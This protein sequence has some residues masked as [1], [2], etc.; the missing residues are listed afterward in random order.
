MGRIFVIVGGFLVLLLTAALVVPPFINWS[1]Y[2]ADF[3]R[4]ASR[5]LGRPV[6]VAG[7]ASARLLPFPSV[8]FSDVRVGASAQNPAM[9]VE[10]FSMGAELMP[11]LRGQLLI[12]DMRVERPRATI[13][14]DKDG[15]VDWAIRPSTPLNPGQ[16]K[17]EKLTISD[18]EINLRDDSSGRSHTITNLDAVLSA[19]SL[20]GPWLTNGRLNFD[21]EQVALDVNTG[22]ARPDGSL[23]MRVRVTP[24]AIPATF[25]TDGD[26]VLDDGQLRYAGNFALRSADIAT[27]KADGGKKPVTE[28]PFLADLRISGVFAADRSRFESAEFRM[29]Q[30]AGDNPYIVNGKALFDYGIEP[31][32]EINADGQQVFWGPTA[33]DENDQNAAIVPLAERMAAF[34]RMMEQLPIPTIPGSVDL[35][36]PAIIAGGTTIRTVNIQAE[37]DAGSWN[38]KQLE[39]DFPGRTKVEAKGRLSVGDNFGFEGDLLVASRQPSGLAA[40]LNENVDESIRRLPAAGFSGR[41]SLNADRQ[42][43]DNLEVGLGSTVLKGRF[44]R[45]SP[46]LAQASID[47]TLAGEAVESDALH[48][49]VAL[50]STDSSLANIGDQ[51]ISVDFKA[52]P[53]RFDDAEFGSVDTAFRLNHGRFD[54]DRLMIGDVGGATLTATGTLNPFSEEPSGSL[55]ATVLADDLSG[56]FTVLA[57]RFPQLPL[58]TALETRAQNY[59][60]LFDDS[61]IN[62]VANALTASKDVATVGPSE[63]SF[64]LSG[65]SGGMKLDLS[66]TAAG[67]VRGEDPMQIQMRA[68]VASQHGETVLALLGLPALPLGMAGPLEADLSLQGAP[69]V[70]MR[71]QLNLK[72]PDGVANVDGVITVLPDDLTASGKASMKAAD[73]QPF[74]A[75]LGY[76]LPG[77]GQGLPV[78]LS[79]DFQLAKGIL[80]FPGLIG[81]VDG[82]EVSAK[83]DASLADDGMPLLRGEAKLAVLDLAAL[84]D[85]MLGQEAFVGGASKGKVPSVWP[86]GTFSSAP[87]L[88]LLADM[89]I[90]AKQAD[91]GSFSP[92]K[93]FTAKIVKGV[94]DLTISEMNG[95]WSGGQLTGRVGLRNNDKN[96]MVSVDMV[97]NG[98]DLRSAYVLED[99]AAPLG[100]ILK[101]TTKLSGNGGNMAELVRSLAGSATINVDG[102]TLSGLEPEALQAMREQADRIGDLPTEASGNKSPDNKATAKQFEAIAS[103][104]TG[105]GSFAAGPA[106]LD[107]TVAGG[108][109]RMSAIKLANRN[110]E[111]ESELQIDLSTLNVTANGS[112][113][114]LA[115]T[116]A[117]VEAGTGSGSEPM[118]RFNV[119]GFYANPVVKV[120]HQPL[121]Q[122]LTQRALER[123]QERVEAMQAQLTEKQALRREVELYQAREAARQAALQQEEERRRTD[124]KARAAVKAKADAKAKADEEAQRAA[125]QRAAEQRSIG[126]EAAQPLN[127]P[128]I[129]L[130]QD[131]QSLNEFLKT[132]ESDPQP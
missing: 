80:R 11:F 43:I 91:L 29:E 82:N 32:F 19:T 86:R 38:I 83:I 57:A 47:L 13:S 126:G 17:V 108:V 127:L 20:S 118:L 67:A 93:D 104:A 3:E 23:R 73:I 61:E 28:K 68:N 81:Q 24:D 84:A 55:D 40:W 34:G 54:F 7:S 110:A 107:L 14:L 109:A 45:Q 115:G 95:T 103:S 125:E 30:G 130:P 76:T 25:E 96:A 78:D 120:D 52:G 71:T 51:A 112:F 65:K 27:R 56:F 131:G 70:G 1:G 48:G 88:P 59:P 22:E 41:V 75:T 132:L 100:G 36:L 69:S 39:A 44:A 35:R 117:G 60:G 74:A 111:L 2:R 97:W 21:G 102:L 9:T 77:F 66:G 49:L 18:G 119:H 92:I 58:F 128:N 122:F 123:E 79:S 116:D 46:R 99:G 114:L 4:E 53:V 10:R 26:M 62:L 105:R 16:I 50:F 12:F 37:P 124:A 42:T 89:K 31:H 90:T 72:A 106:Q 6:E 87:S 33:S 113:R 15:R 5:I 63:I 64:S 8:T 121:V 101:L 129:A 98:A 85:M 94:D